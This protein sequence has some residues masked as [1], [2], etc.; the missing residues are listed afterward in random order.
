LR[1]QFTPERLSGLL[2]N[3]DLRLN[4]L[5]KRSVHPTMKVGLWSKIVLSSLAAGSLLGFRAHA[6]STSMNCADSEQISQPAKLAQGDQNTAGSL[7]LTRKIASEGSLDVEVCFAELTILGGKDDLMRITAT[8]PNP[9]ANKT[10]GDY[11][12]RLDVTEHGA[13]IQLHLPKNTHAKVVVVV[14][15]TMSSLKVN[16][17][18]GSLYF[19]TDRIRGERAI[20]VVS[21]HAALLGNADSYKDLRVNVAFGSFHDHRD[22]TSGH[23]VM[24]SKLLTGT[25]SGSIAISVE[26]GR[27]DLKPWD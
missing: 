18:G 12:Q 4:F 20:N 1:K 14:P 7:Q 24:I 23:G 3:Y 13:G 5:N 10:A 2:R 22:G 15:A 8:L 17:I 19:R 25:G 16:L 27:I 26:K 6:Q 11:L 9:A 21:G